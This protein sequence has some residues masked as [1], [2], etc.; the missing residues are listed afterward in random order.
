MGFILIYKRGYENGMRVCFR[1]R[2]KPESCIQ[3]RGKELPLAWTRANARPE[4]LLWRRILG[5]EALN[6]VQPITNS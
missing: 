3:R 2:R 5:E 4:P 1:G 6:D